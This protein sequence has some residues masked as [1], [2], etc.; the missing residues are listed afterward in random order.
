MDPD[1][2][3]NEQLETALAI[4]HAIDAGREPNPADA[5]RL[6]ELV[7][8]LDEWMRKGGILPKRWQ[9]EW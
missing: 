2:N 9:K 8:A 3:L 4:T 7:L 1:A 6:A 5:E